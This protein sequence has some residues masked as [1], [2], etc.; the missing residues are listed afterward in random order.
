MSIHGSQVIIENHIRMEGVSEQFVD[1]GVDF[2]INNVRS[3]MMRIGW[4]CTEGK[5][6]SSGT[7][8]SV[9]PEGAT[10]SRSERHVFSMPCLLLR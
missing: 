10:T 4:N 6:D 3:R 8:D 1:H 2:F 9:S 5:T 7:Q